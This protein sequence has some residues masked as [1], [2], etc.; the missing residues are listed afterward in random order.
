MASGTDLLR[1]EV[2]TLKSS[3]SLKMKII[4]CLLVC[5]CTYFNA[6]LIDTLLKLWVMRWAV[7][8]SARV[9]NNSMMIIS[10]FIDYLL[11][12]G[13]G[14][15]HQCQVYQL[16]AERNY[17]CFLKLETACVR[18]LISEFTINLNIL[19]CR[20]VVTET[21]NKHRLI[22]VNPGFICIL[23]NAGRHAVA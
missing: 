22:V 20:E 23:Q 6:S 3:S 5:C 16:P 8:V 1:T 14:R 13:K 19:S 4:L 17:F 9:N 10:R 15:Q 11:Y 21:E 12:L 2:V 7:A 18:V